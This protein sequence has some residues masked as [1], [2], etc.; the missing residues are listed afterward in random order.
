[1]PAIV[2][3]EN[4]LTWH[5]RTS[6]YKNGPALGMR[7]PPLYI[8]EELIN[9]NPLKELKALRSVTSTQFA[10]LLLQEFVYMLSTFCVCVALQCVLSLYYSQEEI[11]VTEA[12]LDSV[13]ATK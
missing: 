3:K 7:V 12:D 9:K 13:I 6:K 2:E 10:C 11:M 8:E 4:W 1:M 5:C